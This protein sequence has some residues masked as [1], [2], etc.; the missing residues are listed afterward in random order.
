MDPLLDNETKYINISKESNLEYSP[1]INLSISCK[2]K[3]IK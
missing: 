1:S 3:W 2:E